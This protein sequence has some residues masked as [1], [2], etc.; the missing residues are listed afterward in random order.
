MTLPI[1]LLPVGVD[2]V[3]LDACL[4]ALEAHTPAGTRVWLADDAQA[5]PRG[6]RVIEAW[7]AHTRL[8]A[9]Y[10]R[11]P[12]MLGEV[13]HLDEMLRAC[14]AADVVVLAADAQPLPGWLQQ[15]SA[16]LARD[17]A[18]ASATPWSNAGE[19]CAWPRLGEINPLPD[20]GERLARACAA[21][22]PEHPEL[23]SAVCHAVALRGVA[24]QRAGG[25]DASSYGSWYAA[26]IDLSLR[27]A[28][29]GWRNVLC[30]TAYVGCSGEGC[31]ADGDMDAL[32]T[33]W[34]A[35][36]ARL[37]GFLMHDPLRA[38]REQLQRL[39]AELPPPDPQRALFDA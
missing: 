33:R 2:D 15:L 4:G 31:A 7:L 6:I 29:L 36:H 39:Y 13:A 34:P 16:C 28:G 25:L 26:L 14:A 23:P 8:Q 9:D 10:T 30:E 18:I 37:A 22:P 11:R 32:A 24:R 20:D 3:A 17:A 19:A 35:W 1:V 38:R 12:R 27:M 21:L 5:G